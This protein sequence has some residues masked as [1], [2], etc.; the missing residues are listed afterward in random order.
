MTVGGPEA[1]GRLFDIVELAH[2]ANPGTWQTLNR[3]PPGAPAIVPEL[4]QVTEP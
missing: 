4:P 2:Q 1:E 3:P